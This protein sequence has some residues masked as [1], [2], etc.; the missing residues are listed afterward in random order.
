MSSK[1]K[2]TSNVP[3]VPFYISA[4]LSFFLSL[5][6]VVLSGI[7]AI[8]A[9]SLVYFKRSSYT[10]SKEIKKASVDYLTGAPLKLRDG[11]QISSESLWGNGKGAVVF[12]VRRPG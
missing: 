10:M 8:T 1:R 2:Y 11:T 9:A 3:L 4:V 7:T 5:V 12:A 6:I